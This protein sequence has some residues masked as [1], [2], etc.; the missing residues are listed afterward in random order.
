L[1]FGLC[2]G[3]W[4]A[5]PVLAQVS[6]AQFGGALSIQSDYRYRGI[7]LS[8]RGPAF[9]LDLTYDHPSGFYAGASTIAATQDG[10]FRSL[11]FIEYA[12]YASPRRGGLGWDVG[13]N[14]QNLSYY[15][16]KRY[17]LNYSEVYVG[18]ISDHV[19]ARLHYSPNYLRPGYAALY[20]EV[21]GSVKPAD[22]WR[23][24]GHIGT[25]APIGHPGGRR[26]RYDARVGVA[27]RFGPVEIQASV[28]ATTPNPPIT[29][30]PERSAFVVGASWFF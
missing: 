30:P 5:Q 11:G 17:P 29:T 23:L 16:E 7:S 6:G 25:T 8:N 1:A 28:T 24:F 26:Q 3:L 14:N 10:S 9:I 13:I 18:A 4:L 19:S 15:A 27:R 20:A 12:G 2:S 21:D 22:N